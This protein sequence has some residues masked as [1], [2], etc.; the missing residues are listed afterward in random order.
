MGETVFLLAALV[1]LEVFGGITSTTL[2]HRLRR[3]ASALESPGMWLSS[4][5][6]TVLAAALFVEAIGNC[7]ALL[8]LLPSP[9][10]G[11]PARPEWVGFIIANRVVLL[12]T[13]LYIVAYTLYA[14]SVILEH[15]E[16]GQGGTSSLRFYSVPLILQVHADMNLV[17]LLVLGVAGYSV[18]SRRS[19]SPEWLLFYSML[20]TSHLLLIVAGFTADNGLLYT[21]LG[22]RALAPIVFYAVV[23]AEKRTAS[24]G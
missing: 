11:P 3:V 24:H 8:G 17:A 16:S 19:A 22:L 1:V 20:A 7:L 21:G 18:L 2:S 6:F 14:A 10:R 23:A 9:P 12:A 4:T 5:S 15:V 13:P